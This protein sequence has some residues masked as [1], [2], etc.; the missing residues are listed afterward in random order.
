MYYFRFI[1]Y[2]IGGKFMKRYLR[3]VVF[4]SIIFIMTVIGSVAVN[5]T[6][7]GKCGDSITWTIDGDVL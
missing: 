2:R 6:E 4:V 7:T 3:I 5:A 1:V